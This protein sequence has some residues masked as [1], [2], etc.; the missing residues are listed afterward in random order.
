MP[1]TYPA[2]HIPVI[3]LAPDPNTAREWAHLLLELFKASN[4]GRGFFYEL[5]LTDANALAGWYWYNWGEDCATKVD[6][7][8]E[9]C[10]MVRAIPANED[11]TCDCAAPSGADALGLYRSYNVFVDD[12][13]YTLIPNHKLK[14][15]RKETMCSSA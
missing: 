5:C 13:L 11:L 9:T 4:P 7:I 12:C 1:A 8:C 10:G 15:Y 2:G 6:K 14:S 3:N